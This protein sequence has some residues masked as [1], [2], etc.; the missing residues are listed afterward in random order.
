[1]AELLDPRCLIAAAALGIAEAGATEAEIMCLVARL[2][3]PAGLHTSTE[4]AA[5]A[6]APAVRVLPRP[7]PSSFETVERAL[8]RGAQPRGGRE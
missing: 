7:N 2:M 6:A 5:V 1:M 3:F 8:Q 4:V